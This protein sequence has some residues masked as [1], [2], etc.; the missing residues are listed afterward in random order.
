MKPEI[1][2]YNHPDMSTPLEAT[3]AFDSVWRHA[4]GKD[5]EEVYPYIEAVYIGN[6]D[7]MPLLS[8][9]LLNTILEQYKWSRNEQD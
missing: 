3:I 8:D 6:V 2:I 9:W 5:Y 1:Y 7:I 4:Q